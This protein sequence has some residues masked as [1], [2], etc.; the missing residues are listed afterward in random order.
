MSI[1]LAGSDPDEDAADLDDSEDAFELDSVLTR[2]DGSDGGESVEERLDEAMEG[3][4]AEK[5]RMH[6]FSIGDHVTVERRNFKG[7]QIQEEAVAR[8]IALNSDGT[9]NINKFVIGSIERNVEEK[10]LRLTEEPDE[11]ERR[12]RCV[13]CNSFPIDC[14]CVRFIEAPIETEVPKK[15]SV[16]PQR[17]AK[18]SRL[19]TLD[20][21]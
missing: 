19:A 10:Y 3:D 4:A 8:V 20:D 18:I 7:R 17:S 15:R 13:S 9:Y 1:Y 6:L 14:S 16:Y 12:G 21:R 5:V 11:R 2:D